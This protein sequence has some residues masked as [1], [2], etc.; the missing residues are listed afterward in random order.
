MIWEK[1]EG[2]PAGEGLRGALFRL[3]L[4]LNLVT[5]IAQV[6]WGFLLVLVVGEGKEAGGAARHRLDPMQHHLDP[7][8]QNPLA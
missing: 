5:C 7:M 3:K 2:E 8:Q 6:C 4:S 1:L